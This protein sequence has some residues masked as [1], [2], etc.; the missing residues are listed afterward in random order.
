MTL[1]AF[2]LDVGIETLILTVSRKKMR[3]KLSFLDTICRFYDE[4]SSNKVKGCQW[5]KS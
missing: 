4:I 5:A 2:L 1:S 3:C